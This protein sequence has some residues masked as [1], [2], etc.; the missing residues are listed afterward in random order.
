MTVQER[1]EEAYNDPYYEEKLAEFEA[2]IAR[3]EKIEP[4]DWMPPEYRRQLIRLI[5]QHANS[6]L[7]GALPEGTWIPYA[8]TFKRKM[9]LVAKVQDE[10]GHAQLLYRAA[11]TLGKP[12]EQMVEEL[13]SGESKWSNVFAY[14]AETWADVAIIAWLI[15]A[16]AIINQTI[17]ATG[18]YAP[19]CRALKRIIYEESFHIKHGYEMIVTMVAGTKRQRDM[20]QDALNRWWEPIM[21]F[22]GPPDKLSVHTRTLQRWGVKPKTNDEQR[23]EFLSKYVPQIWDL[24]LEIPDPN[25]RYDETLGRWVYTE[26]D[27][28]KFFRVINGN[29]PMSKERI[30]V[31]RLAY[32]EGR[33]V[34][35]ALEAL[36]KRVLTQPE[37]TGIVA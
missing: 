19:Y 36:A 17:M 24:G 16:A 18:S 33:W 30:A 3:G 14:P 26:P 12:R 31:R 23:Q 34:R 13:L 35:E 7:I 8:P 28:N 20:V 4:D 6:E 29:G 1:Y 2:R 9:A 32:E 25:L 11:E 10:V 22:F 37:P 5:Q 15:D 27:W 21:M